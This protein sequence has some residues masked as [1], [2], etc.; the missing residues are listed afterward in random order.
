[1][2]LARLPAGAVVADLV[3]VPPVTPFLAAA[4]GAGLR[5]VGGLS[6]L[7]H[8]GVLAFERWTGRTAPINAM[9]GALVGA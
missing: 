5:T 2:D 9:R 6:M 3:Y 7:L 1:V 4:A 8:Q